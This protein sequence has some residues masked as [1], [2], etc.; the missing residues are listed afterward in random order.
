MGH[1][2]LTVGY[3]EK[4]IQKHG[5]HLIE[6]NRDVMIAT[7]SA[8]AQFWLVDVFPFCMCAF[9]VMS[10]AL[11]AARISAICPCLVPRCSFPANCEDQSCIYFRR[12]V[13]GISR[14][15]RR[16]CELRY[17]VLYPIIFI[18]TILYVQEQGHRDESLISRILEEEGPSDTLRDSLGTLFLG[19]LPLF[20]CQSRRLTVAV[21]AGTDTVC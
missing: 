3:G 11:N 20:T 12:S 7:T 16:S 13:H 18:P 8:L 19:M 10:G 1:I 2:N 14:S 21:P 6:V 15:T 5:E 17:I 9:V 4:V